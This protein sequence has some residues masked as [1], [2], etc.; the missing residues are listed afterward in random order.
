MMHT[1]RVWIVIVLVLSILIGSNG[2]MYLMVR[3]TRGM[4]V[5]WFKD[6]GQP[7]KKE[8]QSLEEL[9]QRVKA[10]RSNPRDEEE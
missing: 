9:N 10:L 5:N 2:L 6:I 7:W 4:H 1:D 8:D 3:W